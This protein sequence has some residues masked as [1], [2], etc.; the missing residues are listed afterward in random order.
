M[1]SR[2]SLYAVTAVIVAVAASAAGYARDE[3]RDGASHQDAY[4]ASPGNRGPAGV[5]DAVSPDWEGSDCTGLD[6]LIHIEVSG[7]QSDLGTITADLHG[8]HPEEFLKQGKKILRV[9]VP[10]RSGKVRFCMQAP[11]PGVFAIGVYHDQN[12]N[13]R[14]DKDLFGLPAEPYGI[15]NNPRIL[16]GPPS[17]EESAFVVGPEGTNLQ[18]TLRD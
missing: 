6:N 12:A 10:A 8:E 7:V 14:F 15:S 18:I 9:R 13:K 16:F 1:I 2:Q 4:Q 5:P 17:H 11:R 3:P